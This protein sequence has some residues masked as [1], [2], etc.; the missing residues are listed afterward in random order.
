MSGADAV[1]HRLEAAEGLGR[2]VTTMK[3]LASVRVHQFRRSMR[4]LDAST[5]TL[6]RAARVLLHLRPELAE[7]AQGAGAGRTLAVVLGSDRGLCGPFNDRMARYAASAL[8]ARDDAGAGT[9]QGGGGPDVSGV[10]AIGRRLAARLRAA[11]IESDALLE[12]PG[13][14]DTV[15]LGVA[16]LLDLI[17]GWREQGRGERLVLIYARPAG[18]TRFEPRSV[19]VL[20]IDPRWLAQLKGRRWTE[21]RHPVE[22]SDPLRLVQGV[23]RQRMAL[24]FV[25]AFASSLAAENAARLAAMEAASKS[26]EERV[27]EL[28]SA[29][30]SRRQAAVTAELLDIQAASEALAER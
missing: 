22:L 25:K 9:A 2:V 10:V 23:L 6:D 27:E 8:A 29:Y 1:R 5:L 7:V 17:Q 4:A 28:R 20:P 16:D 12:A 14:L 30:H 13:S 3:S 19:Q 21:E 15:E 18:A 24:A 26:V 11:G